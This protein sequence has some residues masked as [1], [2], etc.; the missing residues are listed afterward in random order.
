MQR[1]VSLSGGP[2]SPRRDVTL[3]SPGHAQQ[4]QQQQYGPGPEEASSISQHDKHRINI[5][6]SVLQERLN[7]SSSA[8]SSSTS[9]YA[10]GNGVPAAAHTPGA[11]FGAVYGGAGGQRV[12]TLDDMVIQLDR[13]NERNPFVFN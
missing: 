13:Y 10:G 6:A 4:Q 1:G 12:G 8:A 7:N 5:M 3:E 2:S 11:P 9:F